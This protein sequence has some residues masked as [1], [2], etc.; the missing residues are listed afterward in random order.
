MKTIKRERVS[1]END[2]AHYTCDRCGGPACDDEEDAEDAKLPAYDAAE[3][4]RSVRIE[5]VVGKRLYPT[6]EPLATRTVVDC[7][8]KCFDEAVLP[9][10]RSLGFTPRVED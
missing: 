8:T 7:C 2:V 1:Y 10:L 5:S 3:A 4:I 9:A 6:R